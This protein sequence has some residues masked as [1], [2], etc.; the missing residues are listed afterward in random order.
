MHRLCK[1]SEHR[2]FC[3]TLSETSVL[4]EGVTQERLNVESKQEKDHSEVPFRLKT[5]NYK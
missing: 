5:C 2:N 1:S 4:V 3:S